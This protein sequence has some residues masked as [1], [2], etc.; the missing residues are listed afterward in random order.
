VHDSWKTT[1][2]MNRGSDIIGMPVY[3]PEDKAIP[4]KEVPADASFTR[5]FTLDKKLLQREQKSGVPSYLWALAYTVVGLLAAL[6]IACIAGGTAWAAR[7]A[8]APGQP[9]PVETRPK[10][11][12]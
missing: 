4:A 11:G 10:V 1:L 3:M 7:Q 6:A 2:R 9:A 12:V 5:S 8:K